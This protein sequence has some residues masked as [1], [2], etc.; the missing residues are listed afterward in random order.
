M[1][2][3][4]YKSVEVGGSVDMSVA[5]KTTE[6]A[7]ER[8]CLDSNEFRDIIGIGL[9]NVMNTFNP[10]AMIIGNR[11]AR[12]EPWIKNPIERVLEERLS[13]HHP[14]PTRLRFSK[15]KDDS[16]ALG[17]ASFAISA[18]FSNQKITEMESLSFT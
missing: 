1:S 16:T 14:F 12:F 9:T 15:L 2:D 13:N 4:L 11:I 8:R 3:Q 5:R 18:F 6:P 17:A 7:G 10:E